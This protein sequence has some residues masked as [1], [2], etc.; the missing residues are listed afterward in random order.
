MRAEQRPGFSSLAILWSQKIKEGASSKY[1][2]TA[3]PTAARTSCEQPGQAGRVVLMVPICFPRRIILN[4]PHWGQS[5]AEL[6]ISMCSCLSLQTSHLS[7]PQGGT[8]PE[9]CPLL[10]CW[11]F[12][13]FIIPSV[14]FRW[15]AWMEEAAHFDMNSINPHSKLGPKW[16]YSSFGGNLNTMNFKQHL[17]KKADYCPAPPSHLSHQHIY[18]WK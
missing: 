2:C 3:A 1:F 4:S 9:I 10:F 18:K 14:V 11:L 15:S 6:I 12:Y 8:C 17:V 16:S 7:H 13:L 5:F